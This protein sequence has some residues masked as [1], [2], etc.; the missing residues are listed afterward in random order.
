MDYSVFNP[1]FSLVKLSREDGKRKRDKAKAE[2]RNKEKE[3]KALVV[4]RDGSHYCRLIPQCD[5]KIQFETAHLEDKGMGGDHGLRTDAAIMVR[6]CYFHH[7]GNWS[8]HSNDLR[9][10][11]LTNE[12]ANGPIQIWGRMSTGEWYLVGREKAVGVWERD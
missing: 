2:I 3:Q 11:Y 4:K 1:E 8:L 6:S 9:V 5:E 10:E 12:K 7:R